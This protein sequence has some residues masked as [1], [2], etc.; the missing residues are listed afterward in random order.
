[1][2]KDK[3]IYLRVS[4]SELQL[5]QENAKN[6][7]FSNMSKYIRALCI[8]NKSVHTHTC[9]NNFCKYEVI[10]EVFVA[11]LQRILKNEKN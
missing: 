4:D 6:A 2:K 10:L 1:M 7:G 11:T 9:C 3:R 8:N 5:L